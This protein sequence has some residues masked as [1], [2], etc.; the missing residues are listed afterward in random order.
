[1]LFEKRDKVCILDYPFGRAT[2]L[3]G[4][5]MG[6]LPGDNYN[7]M[8]ENGYNEGKLVKYKYWRLKKMSEIS[9]GAEI[10]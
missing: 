4:V 8:M 9:K 2:N 6:S 10:C 7:V 5:V 3:V 1:M